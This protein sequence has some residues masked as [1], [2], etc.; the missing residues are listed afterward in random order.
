MT[1]AIVNA[2]GNYTGTGTGSFGTGT[3]TGT[4][5]TGTGALPTLP[6]IPP[7]TK[8][9]VIGTTFPAGEF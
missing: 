2:C 6:N 1:H 3:C 5:R 9:T 4:V 7:D 8:I